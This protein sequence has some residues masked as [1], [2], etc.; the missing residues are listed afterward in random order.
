[1]TA[2][3]NDV[4]N[5]GSES[6]DFTITKASQSINFGS[7]AAV[8]IRAP[9]FSLGAT[10]SSGLTVSYTSS[11]PAVASVSSGMVTVVSGGTTTITAS[12]AGDRNY[13]AASPV[14]QT[15]RVQTAWDV[16]AASYNLTGAARLQAADPDG[17]GFSNAQEFAFGT[18]PTVPNFKLFEM[19]EN[20]GQ[21]VV[22]FL[23]RLDP[24]DAMYD[25]R[26]STDLTAPFVNGTGMTVYGVSDQSSLPSANYERTSVRL[27]IS[28]A[29][30]FI[31]MEATVL[32]QPS[33]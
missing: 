33:P 32:T 30:G 14:T 26:S 24:A 21:L 16:W 27:P 1:M 28:G 4:N 2:T 25:I 20:S 23:W 11:N 31:R 6:V 5:P 12:Q 13:A 8:T 29:R 7:L 18:N 10:A 22:T 17:D 9:N 15:L 3:S 19:A